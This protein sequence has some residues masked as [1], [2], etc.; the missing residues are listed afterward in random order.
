MPVYRQIGKPIPGMI[1]TIPEK[2]K[3]ITE[4]VATIPKIVSRGSEWGNFLSRNTKKGEMT[5]SLG[6]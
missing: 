5:P 6:V 2:L 1:E 3:T 4:I